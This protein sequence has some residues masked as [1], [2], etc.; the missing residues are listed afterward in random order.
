MRVDPKI[1]QWLT[2]PKSD[3]SVRLRFLAE[4]EGKGPTDAGVRRAK[5]SIGRTGWASWL[6]GFQYPD[7]HWV[8][9]GTS[10]R[11]LMRPRLVSTYWV[12]NVLADLGMERS[13]PRI[14]RTGE[15]ILGLQEQV[16][17]DPGSDHCIG[18]NATRTLIQFGYLDHP[19]VQRSLEWLIRSQKPDGGWHCFPS[20][21][22]TLDCWEGLAALAA[23]PE[24]ARDA[25]TR[26]AIERNAEFYLERRLMREGKQRYEPWFRI[27]FPNHYHY[28]LLVGLRLLARLGYGSD[29]RLRPA[30]EWLASKRR[31]DGS[32][33]LDAVH[34][35][36][37][38]GNFTWPQVMLPVMFE[39]LHERSQWATAAALGVLAG[40]ASK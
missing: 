29:P 4:V 1:R 5:E 39:P 16:L 37:E 40:V 2:G 23:I 7:G 22:G 10:T 25:A 3:P 28:D 35:D 8:T 12:A 14:R 34:P 27:H 11:E 20:R 26:R 19:V 21:S 17:A 6:L 33:A 13:D 15:L 30:L 9:P 36:E 18:A 32:W 24:G 31:P 38:F